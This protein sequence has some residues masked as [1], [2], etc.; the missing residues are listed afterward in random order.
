MANTQ[1]KFSK[2]A[3]KAT[4]LCDLMVG[5]DKLSTEEVLGKE[6]TIIAFDFA[7]KFDKDSGL[8]VMMDDGQPDT[9]GVV[10][11]QEH[12]DKYYSVGVVFTKVCHAWAA[13]YDGDVQAAS[14]DLAM[15]GG[16]KVRLESAKTK[17][18]NNLT[19]VV[20]L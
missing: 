17:R 4:T 6:L 15:A 2:M 20:I 19:Q 16:C 12:P 7:P 13:E 3:Q 11:F 5:R 14:K 10:V 1:N 18:G 8:M 9:F